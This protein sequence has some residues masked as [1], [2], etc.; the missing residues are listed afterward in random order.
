MSR[1]HGQTIRIVDD[2][3][4][5]HYYEGEVS[6]NTELHGNYITIELTVDAQ[7]FRFKRNRTVFHR[8]MDGTITIY[9]DNESIDAVPIITVTAETSITYNGKTVSLS[10]GTYTIDDFVL[11]AGI[12]EVVISCTGAV[13]IEYQEGAI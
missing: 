3:Y 11:H 7:P 8:E 1:F 5:S 10:A 4:P 9:L 12:N 6:V 13:T 2:D